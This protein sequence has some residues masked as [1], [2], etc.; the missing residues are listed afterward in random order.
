VVKVAAGTHH[1]IAVKAD[2][3]AVAWGRNDMGQGSIPYHLWGFRA[4]DAG[5]RNN[6]AVA[7]GRII[8]VPQI[9]EGPSSQPVVQGG[10]ATFTVTAV[11]E[12]LTYSWLKNGLTMAGATSNV[13]NIAGAQTWD[14]GEYRAVVSNGAGSV[15]SAVATLTVVVPPSIVTQPQSLSRYK[16]AMYFFEVV[17]GGTA[18]FT[19]SWFKDGSPVPNGT[20]RLMVRNNASE[21]NAG[22]YRVVVSNFAGSVTSAPASL[23]LL[24]DRPPGPLVSLDWPVPPEQW[25]N[26]VS[27][28]ASVSHALVLRAD[29]TVKGWTWLTYA[30]EA[31]IVPNGLSGVVAVSAGDSFSLALKSDG[32]VVGWGSRNAANV[33][34]G[35]SGVVAIAAG[36]F[37]S[38]ALK[39][40]GSLVKWGSGFPAPAVT[41]AVAIAAG[42]DATAALRRDGT[43]LT[44]SGGL[45]YTNSL[46]QH[47]DIT[48]GSYLKSDGTVVGTGVPPWLSQVVE[49]S[50]TGM[51]LR[52]D[53]TVARWTA[54]TSSVGGFSNV[55]A[56]CGKGIPL[57]VTHWP[58]IVQH[59]T[60][61]TA[62]PNTSVTFSIVAKGKA[63]FT[64]QW[65]HNGTEISGETNAQ[66]VIQNTIFAD[67]GEY[68]VKVSNNS[69][70]VISSAG[71]LHL[72]G[73]PEITVQPVGQLVFTGAK[74]AFSVTAIGANP[75]Y[76]QWYRGNVAI[77]GATSSDLVLPA[78]SASDVGS[79]TVLVSNHIGQVTSE[80]VN[81]T[82][83][84][85]HAWQIGVPGTVVALNGPAIPPGLTNVTAV[86]AGYTH[87]MALKADST[88]VAWG[89]VGWEEASVPLGLSNVVAI[90]AGE[91]HS[92]AL[93]ADGTV[94]GWGP[95]SAANVPPNLFG[96]TA[97]AAGTDRS[98]A[99]QS[100]GT[101]L[102]WRRHSLSDPPGKAT[103]VVALD[104]GFESFI[105]LRKDGTVVT[106]GGLSNPGG[107]F[108]NNLTNI[109]AVSLAHLY[110]M[111]L[112]G[113]G[114]VVGSPG[115]SNV[116]AIAAGNNFGLALKNDGTV[117]GIGIDVPADLSGVT[118]IATGGFGLAI[119]TNPPQ[120]RLAMT[121]NSNGQIG[122]LSTVSVPNYVLESA[123]QAG[124]FSEVPGY[125]NA[126]YATNSEAFEFKVTPDANVRIYR[127][128]KQ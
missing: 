69:G 40:D 84:A 53:G 5:E 48:W 75:L 95:I 4:I 2:G 105:A 70:Y 15:T 47:V 73:T 37:H 111:L 38:V 32:T 29:G 52:A 93:L 64:Y 88:V 89:R 85:A 91:R 11:G 100:D 22:E 25:D 87:A 107:M 109:A 62:Q 49:V 79:Y 77:S 66:L 7:S 17:A 34:A 99:L 58:V 118:A 98:M 10:I 123:T 50:G 101:I 80:A 94:V 114:A 125:T 90:S 82:L 110:T 20:S 33:P 60:I 104:A 127:L 59:P 6:L 54:A 13:L 8:G 39:E 61:I 126:F 63:P 71:R 108:E 102:G 116:L 46:D 74:V 117:T 78:T 67:T 41:D 44:R 92:L 3:S 28:D 65:Q 43:I 16:R 45:V 120:P 9:T 119:T 72:F 121:M 36:G 55:T 83:T 21:S 96:V 81:L 26:V 106:W 76:Y 57:V 115:L 27:M 68:L 12:E 51:A 35:L 1:S 42:F 31:D 56:I 18:P 19:Y 112:N 128:R 30:G 124:A 97:I 113:D 14:A 86:A 103:N 24:G 122:V 23:V